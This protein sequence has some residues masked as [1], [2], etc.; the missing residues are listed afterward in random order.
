MVGITKCSSP[1]SNVS[2]P[3]SSDVNASPSSNV[4]NTNEAPS[5]IGLNPTVSPVQVSN[6][7]SPSNMGIAA[8]VTLPNAPSPPLEPNT[9]IPPP[10]VAPIPA[11]VTPSAS[12]LSPLDISSIS[13]VPVPVVNMSATGPFLGSNTSSPSND[14]KA[15]S[16]PDFTNP[17]QLATEDASQKMEP[18][19]IDSVDLKGSESILSDNVV[20]V[21]EEPVTA[22]IKRGGSGDAGDRPA[23]Q[24]KR[25]KTIKFKSK[26]SEGKNIR[27]A[28]MGLPHEREETERIYKRYLHQRNVLETPYDESDVKDLWLEVGE[29]AIIL[30]GAAV[31]PWDNPEL[32]LPI[33]FR[34]SVVKN[35]TLL[36]ASAC[37]RVA[38]TEHLLTTARDLTKCPPCYGQAIQLDVHVRYGY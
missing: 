35:Q 17:S 29:A 16:L 10:F 4:L 27:V 20:V 33:T 8:N 15:P 7:P 19:V 2:P 30:W 3:P 11:S 37:T 26:F 18:M 5:A 22:G 1:P 25:P 31:N 21:V 14:V 12:A 28:W 34:D 23:D 6:V 32:S 36:P 9:D 13:P 24:V 38:L